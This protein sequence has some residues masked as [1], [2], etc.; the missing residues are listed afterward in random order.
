MNIDQ[1]FTYFKVL[2]ARN[3]K[4]SSCDSCISS[5]LIKILIR[6]LF[7]QLSNDQRH[8]IVENIQSNDYRMIDTLGFKE[9]SLTDTNIANKISDQCLCELRTA[10]DE[11]KSKKNVYSYNKLVRK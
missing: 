2:N 5:S 9:I 7:R 10:F 4:F 8:I 3:N 6:N 1:R 11:C